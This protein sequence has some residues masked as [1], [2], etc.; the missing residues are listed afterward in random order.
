MSTTSARAWTRTSSTTSSLGCSRRPR[1][2][3]SR[4]SA[5]S[6]SG[7]PRSSPSEPEAVLLRTGR[8]GE[9]WELLFHADRSFDKVRIDRA[10]PRHADHPVQAH[11]GEIESPRFVQEVQFVL[12]LLVRALRHSDH[13]RRIGLE[14]PRP[15]PEA[16]DRRS[17]RR[18]RR[19][20][21]P[22]VRADQPSPGPAGGTWSTSHD[23][24]GHRGLSSD[25]R[26]RSRFGY[27]N[28]GLTLLN[29]QNTRRA[30][31][32]TARAPAPPGVQGQARRSRAHADPRQRA[33][34]PQL[35]DRARCRWSWPPGGAA[36]QA[37]GPGHRARGSAGLGSRPVGVA[38]APSPPSAV[39]PGPGSFLEDLEKRSGV[40]QPRGGRR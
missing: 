26:P 33:A 7:S 6:A 24:D 3:T 31:G 37:G 2:M 12:G 36:Q 40:P 23:E 38:R 15:E 25:T 17:V 14:P 21:A 28:G 8:H 29:T 39:A 13:L 18:F 5:S 34:R 16:D 19:A 4:R 10:G 32:S 35:A 9:Y 22:L 27:Y 30:R 20:Q 1:R 11:A